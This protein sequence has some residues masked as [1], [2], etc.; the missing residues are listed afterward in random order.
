MS[1]EKGLNARP[2]SKFSMPDVSTVEPLSSADLAVLKEVRQVLAKHGALHRFGVTLQHQHFNLAD[3]EI[4]VETTDI[5]NRV[6]TI[7]PMKRS[8]QPAAVETA[9]IFG[10]DEDG[11]KAAI[12][13]YL[14]RYV[15]A[16][17]LHFIKH[18]E[19]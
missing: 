6:Q 11:A 1:D 16:S 15:G 17:G 3:D 4:M 18:K 2:I 14:S 7:R 12:K 13:C 10:S 19:W 9:W 5:A 8:E